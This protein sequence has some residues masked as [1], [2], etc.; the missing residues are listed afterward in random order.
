MSRGWYHHQQHSHSSPARPRP[1]RSEE[2]SHSLSPAKKTTDVTDIKKEAV[3][4]ELGGGAD[5]PPSS[6]ALRFK[7]H[8]RT[9]TRKPPAPAPPPAPQGGGTLSPRP[10]SP[11]WCLLP[12]TGALSPPPGPS[13]LAELV[14]RLARRRRRRRRR[15]NRP[16]PPPPP[17]RRS[18]PALCP[19]LY[20]LCFAPLAP[21][22]CAG[23]VNAR[24]KQG[25][26]PREGGRGGGG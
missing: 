25:Q 13:W 3:A 9:C 7:T 22:P 23:S 5:P 2:R 21:P 4:G 12:G 11:C 24:C 20:V 17:G 8:T 15:R 6:C 16:P 18:S 19:V 14:A 1:T 26:G 10:W